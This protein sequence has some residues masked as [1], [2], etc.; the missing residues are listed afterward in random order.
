MLMVLYLASIGF[1]LTTP[2]IATPAFQE[3]PYNTEPIILSKTSVGQTP[4]N[5]KEGKLCI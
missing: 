3:K 4:N 2:V 1:L 5:C